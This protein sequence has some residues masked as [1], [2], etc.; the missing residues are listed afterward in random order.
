MQLRPLITVRAVEDLSFSQAHKLIKRFHNTCSAQA[1]QSMSLQHGRNEPTVSDDTL[2]KLS[3]LVTEVK[4]HADK[5]SDGTDT[6]GKK[7]RK[8]E[9]EFQPTKNEEKAIGDL[10][11]EKKKKKSKKSDK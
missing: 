3:T 2:D 9:T 11:T 6:A 7:K 4:R 1:S 8:R 10:S 5:Q